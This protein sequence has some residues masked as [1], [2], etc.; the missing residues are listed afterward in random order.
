MGKRTTKLNCW[1]FKKCGREPGGA[2]EQELGICIS[3][4]ETSVDGINGGLNGGR[5]CWAVAGTLSDENVKGIFALKIKNCLECDFY[6]K[7]QKEEG[8]SFVHK[9]VFYHY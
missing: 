2:K 4:K 5:I 9:S 8:E 6:K 3:T 7:V 1:E